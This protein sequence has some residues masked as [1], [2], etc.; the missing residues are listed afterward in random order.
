MEKKPE[1]KVVLPPVSQI[2]MLVKDAAKTAAY[3]T[4]TF[5]IGPFRS[6]DIDMPQGAIY[7]GKP[8]KGRLRIAVAR[9]GN[10][11]IELIQVLE[12]GEFYTKY[13]KEKGEG[14]HHLGVNI[15]N[16]ETYDRILAQLAEKGVK[17][18]FSVKAPG[19]ACAYLETEGGLILEPIYM[20][21]K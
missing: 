6:Y 4:A 11:D 1:G 17:P 7:K 13:L 12:G 8:A 10:M 2:G 9:M 5:G 15:D 18:S 16:A 20:Q 21:R 3:Y 19:V 14:L